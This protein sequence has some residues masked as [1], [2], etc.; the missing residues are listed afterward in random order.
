M[1]ATVAG[2]LPLHQVV[3]LQF[4]LPD[5]AEPLVLRAEVRYRHGFQYGFKLLALTGEELEIIR[6][7]L[8]ALERTD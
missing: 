1:G 3:E 5:S 2:D 6:K 7:G 8:K 4:Q